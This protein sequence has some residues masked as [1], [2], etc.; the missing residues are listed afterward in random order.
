MREITIGSNF[1][2]QNPTGQIFG[3][4]ASTVVDE[5]VVE[6]PPVAAESGPMRLGTRLAGPIAASQSGQTLVIRQ[7]DRP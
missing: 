1:T 6:W 7:P 3:L 4:G 5:I 2:S